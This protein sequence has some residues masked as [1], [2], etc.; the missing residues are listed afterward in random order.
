MLKPKNVLFKIC[1]LGGKGVLVS[2][3]PIK[4]MI[5]DHTFHS[6]IMDK[7]TEILELISSLGCFIS[8]KICVY[9]RERKKRAGIK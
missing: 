2:V 1:P 6:S 4:S 9:I 8:N 5:Y 3:G 7:L